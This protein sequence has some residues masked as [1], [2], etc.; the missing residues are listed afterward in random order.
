[1]RPGE[2]LLMTLLEEASVELLLLARADELELLTCTAVELLLEGFAVLLLLTAPLLLWVAA[3]TSA[4]EL[5]QTPSAIDDDEEEVELPA[6]RASLPFPLPLEASLPLME[7]S[8]P[9]EPNPTVS[10]MMTTATPAA[11]RRARRHSW[12]AREQED[13]RRGLLRAL[14][15]ASE[16]C[17]SRYSGD[18][19][20]PTRHAALS[21]GYW[22]SGWSRI[23]AIR[24]LAERFL[25]G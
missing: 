2:L 9:P 6:P 1:M 21:C 22:W 15:S 16:C 17:D 23:T 18:C 25:T 24:K 7:G 11:R 20:T 4:V 12:V 19:C 13:L 5:V 14:A 8:L 10:Q 3:M